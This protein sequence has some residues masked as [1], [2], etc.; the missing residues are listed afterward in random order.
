MI[1]HSA[2]NLKK[3]L[4]WQVKEFAAAAAGYRC[5]ED[6]V[7]EAMTKL[8]IPFDN[9]VD[10]HENVF[11]QNPTPGLYRVGVRAAAIRADS[12]METPAVDAD[13]ATSIGFRSG[14]M[15]TIVAKRRRVVAVAMAAIATQHSGHGV[16]SVNGG[17]PV[18]EY[19]YLD[20]R[21]SG[22]VVSE[23]RAVIRRQVDRDAAAMICQQV[24]DGHISLEQAI[25]ALVAILHKSCIEK[26]T[27][28]RMSRIGGI[29]KQI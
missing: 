28:W 5:G 17:S 11:I 15:C 13:F 2:T 1:D 7:Q 21:V 22:V 20:S 27:N 25:G 29:L 16:S 9:D 4:N 10:I 8:R 26:L 14:K 3:N 23:E 18:S 24:R 6:L 19:G 12:H